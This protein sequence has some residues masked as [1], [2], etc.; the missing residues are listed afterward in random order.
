M[1]PFIKPVTNPTPTTHPKPFFSKYKV[2]FKDKVRSKNRN[3]LYVWDCLCIPKSAIIFFHEI[4][5]MGMRR[6]AYCKT[7]CMQLN[8]SS[9]IINLISSSS[10]VFTNP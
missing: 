7:I 1:N 10:H 2:R 6:K 4:L 5:L 9:D 8:G 3:T